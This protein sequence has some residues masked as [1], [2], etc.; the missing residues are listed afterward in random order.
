MAGICGFI[1]SEHLPLRKEHVGMLSVMV[2]KLGIEA[3]QPS[4]MLIH[5]RFYL[6]NV[7]LVEDSGNRNYVAWEQAGIH[8]FTEGLVFISKEQ[9]DLLQKQYQIPGDE[10]DKFY[11]PY[12]YHRYGEAMWEHLSGNYNLTILDTRKNTCLIL[13]DRL[14]FLPLFVYRN[15]DVFAFSSRIESLLA[16]GWIEDIRFDT[17][18]ITEHLFFNHIL[19][20]NSFIKEVSTLAPASRVDFGPDYGVRKS[21][22]WS[23]QSLIPGN[24]GSR[25]S[26]LSMLDTGLKNA[27]SKLR[28][29][30]G[31]TLNLSL[32]GGWDSRVVL[33]YAK[34][35]KDTIHAYSFGAE[36]SPD[37]RIPALISRGEQ[38][39]YSPFYLDDQYLENSFLSS[40]KNTILSSNG[41]RN[42]KRAHYLYSISRLAKESDTIL[43]GIYGDEVL[44]VTA[45]RPG[46]V[47]SANTLE[48]IKSGF[49][50]AGITK[51]VQESAAGYL[52]K[53]NPELLNEFSERMEHIRQA[54]SDYVDLTQKYYYFRF[55]IGLRKYFGV[56]VNSYN[57]YNY[58][59]SPFTDIDF[60]SKYF[61]SYYSGLKGGF[62]KDSIKLKYRTTK[63]YS[64]LIRTNY[65]A[66]AVYPTDRGYSMQ[67]IQSVAGIVKIFWT[68][69]SRKKNSPDS[70]NTRKTADI[71]KK[72]YVANSDYKYSTVTPVISDSYFSGNH[73]TALSLFY[74]V[75]HI[76]QRYSTH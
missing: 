41:Q 70:F 73:A 39:R 32:T 34:D 75:A 29:A 69:A 58:N 52:L 74:W 3:D 7:S 27:F 17:V 8:C 1:L 66:L 24:F 12:C 37:I 36:N 47:L 26:A 13:N 30:T 21:C 4:K 67:D 43:S 72:E 46:E 20:D 59:F 71:F 38:I 57:D 53:T 62:Q 11:L 18:S 23:F 6:G 45:P 10:S 50:P 56:E 44:K 16:S 68:Q 76:A 35:W 63:L 2:G 15:K 65:P 5:E 14:G 48:L 25:G 19:S 40:A 51:K 42:F 22:Y 60:L 55:M 33:S 9:K 31:R 28:S 49:D 54:A 61:S 64:D